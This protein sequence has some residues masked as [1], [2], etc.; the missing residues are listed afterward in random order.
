MAGGRPT[1]YTQPTRDLICAL[2]ASGKSL[3]S[4]CTHPDLPA[5][6][7]VIGWLAD[8]SKKEFLLQY[9]A[10][11]RIQLELKADELEDLAAADV[12]APDNSVAIAR[13]RLVV[14]T[15]KF[16]LAKLMPK[17]YG[18][19]IE[20]RDDDA[21]NSADM[22]GWSVEDVAALLALKRKYSGK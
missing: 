9:E 10:A 19:F 11:R 5:A 22:S 12:S 14:D 4:I 15:R 21:A 13:D 7:T 2:L 1:L 16:V 20:P 18:D 8:S 6:S 17:K 3:R